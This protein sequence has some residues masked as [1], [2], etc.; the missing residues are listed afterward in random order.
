MNTDTMRNLGQLFVRFSDQ[1]RSQDEP[2]VQSTMAD[3]ESDWQ[4]LSRQRYDALYQEWQVEIERLLALGA[5]LGQHMQ[6][7]AQ[8]LESADQQL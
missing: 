2:G 5:S 1:I 6:H 8:S 4:G 7:C 3:L